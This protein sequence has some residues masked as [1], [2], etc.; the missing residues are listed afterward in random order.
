MMI[1]LMIFQI[2]SLQTG[3]NTISVFNIS[4]ILPLPTLVNLNELSLINKLRENSVR[5]SRRNVE[6]SADIGVHYKRVRFQVLLY[7]S[8]T[9]RTFIR[10]IA[11]II[12][13]I[14]CF[15][16]RCFNG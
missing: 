14:D 10:T 1:L 16:E 2:F 12:A 15:H 5:C 9:K 8:P 13:H 6:Q 7:L 11:H 4:L 3:P